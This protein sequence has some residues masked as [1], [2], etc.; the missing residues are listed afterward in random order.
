L[1]LQQQ[2]Q[3]AGQRQRPPVPQFNTNN[4]VPA[5]HQ[6]PAMDLNTSFESYTSSGFGSTSLNDDLEDFTASPL[7]GAEDLSFNA[8]TTVSS[9][10]VS[11]HDLSLTS[12]YH[13]SAPA[14]AAMTNLTTPDMGG[15]EMS[16]FNQSYDASPLFTG[17][18]EFNANPEWYSLF[19]ESD[20]AATVAP[21][22]ERNISQTSGTGSG[23]NSNS[24]MPNGKKP[25]R[26]SASHRHSLST[27]VSKPRRRTG[28][29]KDIVIDPTDKKAYKRA[30]NTLAARESRGRKAQ[31][32]EYM[33]SLIHDKDQTI[34]AMKEALNKHGYVGTF[35]EFN[36]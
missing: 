11:P 16:P 20:A 22:M 14:S 31:H 33:E 8:G 21:S 13:G 29:M 27:G 12:D 10:T 19:P 36:A 26:P 1:Y 2:Q 5:Q 25:E 24:P 9:T 6:P 17:T 28:P 7:F 3:F 4:S 30:K 23:S 34:A 15:V 32:M 35:T 18:E